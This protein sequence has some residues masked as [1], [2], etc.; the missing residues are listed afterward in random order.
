MNTL[1]LSYDDLVQVVLATEG[2]LCLDP[3]PVVSLIAAKAH[4]S[5]TKFSTV[6]LRRHATK[7]YS[8]AGQNRKRKLESLAAPPELALHDFI[9]TLNSSSASAAG[10]GSGAPPGKRKQTPVEA[11]RAHQDSSLAAARVAEATQPQPWTHGCLS[12]ASPELRL[13]L[14]AQVESCI[15]EDNITVL[16][17]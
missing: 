6:P 11:L 1:T 14:P 8:Q 12:L 4:H 3:N 15:V 10:A 9:R 7:R 2:P 5:R 17:V 16:C 13:A